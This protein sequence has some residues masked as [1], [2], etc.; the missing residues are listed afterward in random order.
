M[1]DFMIGCGMWQLSD[2][3]PHAA[4]QM[5]A[6]QLKQLTIETSKKTKTN[7]N[8]KHYYYYVFK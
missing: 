2:A 3:T 1:T 8:V 5:Q 7:E 4:R 6:N